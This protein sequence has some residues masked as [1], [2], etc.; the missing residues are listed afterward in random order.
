MAIIAPNS[1]TK[2]AGGGCNFASLTETPLACHVEL[3]TPRD[4]E[5]AFALDDGRQVAARSPSPRHRLTSC[6]VPCYSR[7]ELALL[8]VPAVSD[9]LAA[10]V[11]TDC[12]RAPVA[13]SY[14]DDTRVTV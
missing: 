1:N 5:S 7:I 2:S 12:A 10:Q 9:T 6:R 11:P 4:V 3:E 14:D 13:A 8:A